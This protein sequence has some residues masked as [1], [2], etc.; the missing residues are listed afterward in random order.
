MPRKAR[1]HGTATEMFSMARMPKWKKHTVDC[2]QARIAAEQFQETGNSVYAM[3]AFLFARKSGVTPPSNVLEWLALCFGKYLDQEGAESLDSILGLNRGKGKDGA[4]KKALLA[5][6]DDM[7]FHDMAKLRSLSLDLTV[8]EA[9]HMVAR[10]LE[11]TRGWNKTR[12]KLRTLQSETLASKYN[13]W[14][15]RRQEERAFREALFGDNPALRSWLPE[16]RVE[17]VCNYLREFP[18]DSLPLR[19]KRL[20]GQRLEP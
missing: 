19:L 3:E 14:R 16:W 17:D 20:L 10:R 5:Q 9:A 4:Y 15:G 2:V 12:W 13:R 8:E 7:L 6:R 18:G 11:E 1:P